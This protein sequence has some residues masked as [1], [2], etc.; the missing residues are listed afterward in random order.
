MRGILGAMPKPRRKVRPNV[1]SLRDA[2]AVPVQ[3]TP[4]ARSLQERKRKGTPKLIATA[5]QQRSREY[6]AKRGQLRLP[7]LDPVTAGD[8]AKLLMAGVPFDSVLALCDPEYYAYVHGHDPDRAESM[9]SKWALAWQR[10]PLLLSANT[11]LVGAEW[12]DLDGERRLQIAIDKHMAELA[13]LLYSRSYATLQGRDVDKA[14]NA[15]T[16]IL[17]YLAAKGGDP[18]APWVKYLREL[19]EKVDSD[20]VATMLTVPTVETRSGKQES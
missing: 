11:E 2:A 14:D 19:T 16:A 1:T 17:E 3:P 12:Q 10:D 15:R 8:V 4:S 9:M 13:Y 20:A 5:A 6:D 7:A 18:S